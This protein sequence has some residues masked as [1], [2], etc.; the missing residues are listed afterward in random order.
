MLLRLYK[1]LLAG[2]AFL[3]LAASAYGAGDVPLGEDLQRDGRHALDQ[4][5]PILLEFSAASCM[6][7]RQ[8][9]RE[10]LV[11][12]LI[13]GEY[14]DKAIIRRLLLD[15]GAYITDFD[16][17]RKPA[18]DVA[19]RYRAWITPTLVFI[20]GRGNEIT[21]RMIGINT[22][23]LF[24]GYLDA[25]IDTALLKIRDPDSTETFAGCSPVNAP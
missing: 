10:F 9:E 2:G 25:C 11:P 18:S 15:T 21:E 22:P 23:E 13:S 6:Y 8:L 3:C 4:Q 12:M 16:G 24:G 14:T 1:S 17:E 19:S 7:C 5:L 20:D